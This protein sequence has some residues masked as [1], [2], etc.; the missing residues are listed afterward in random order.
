MPSLSDNNVTALIISIPG[1]A[2]A[3]ISLMTFVQN[4][5][6]HKVTTEKVEH[7]TSTVNGKM[8]EL[9]EVTKASSFAEGEKH[10]KDTEGASS[11]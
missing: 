1:I 2:A 4:M 11:Q 9:L 10:Q 5:L 6:N 8:T 3:L 7:L